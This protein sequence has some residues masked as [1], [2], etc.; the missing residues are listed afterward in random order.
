M[1]QIYI[2]AAEAFYNG[3]YFSKGNTIIE[4][5]FTGI[6]MNLHGNCIATLNGSELT[7]SSC[8][9][10]TATTRARLNGLLTPYGFTLS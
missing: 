10:K 1:K 8:G 9:W 2:D 5:L 7:V 6:H 4:N 3:S